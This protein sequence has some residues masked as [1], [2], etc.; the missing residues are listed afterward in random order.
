VVQEG[1]G[2]DVSHGSTQKSDYG[3]LVMGSDNAC[4]FPKLGSFV[5]FHD[6]TPKVNQREDQVLTD[7]RPRIY[8]A[9]ERLY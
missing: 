9:T 4:P 1:H 2:D 6:V 7:F 5:A 8:C 3:S